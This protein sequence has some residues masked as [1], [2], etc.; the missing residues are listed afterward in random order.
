MG[1]SYGGGAQ[2]GAG[3]DYMF[4]AHVNSSPT[5]QTMWSG[6]LIFPMKTTSYNQANKCYGHIL[7]QSYLYSPIGCQLND[8]EADFLTGI[9]IYWV[10]DSGSPGARAPSTGRVTLLRMKYS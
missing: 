7:G 10:D 2:F 1:N 3:G 8:G 4:P 6:E 5:A 9:H